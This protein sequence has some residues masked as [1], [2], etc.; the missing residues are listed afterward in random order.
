M[1]DPGKAIAYLRVST[2][3]QHLGPAAQRRAIEQWAASQGVSVVAWHADQGV[4]GG[5][6][7]EH[8]PAL[9]AAVDALSEHRAGVLVV[10]K[11]DRLARDVGLAAL[12]DRLVARHGGRVVSAAG[13]G[14]DVDRDDPTGLLYRGLSDLLAQHERAVIRARTRAALAVKRA[15]GERIGAVPFG[16]RLAPDDVRIEPDPDEQAIIARVRT[17]R[18]SGLAQRSI[19]GVLQSEGVVSRSGRPLS[20]TQVCRIL[21]TA[22]A[23]R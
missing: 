18:A 1:G 10:A 12:V 9:L 5:A 7:L 2:E 16:Y 17:L 8:R 11:R 4:S 19:V 20:Q 6:E 13:E 3:D 15:R 21:Q 23:A 14:T 22:E